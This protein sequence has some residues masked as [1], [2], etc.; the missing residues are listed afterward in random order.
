VHGPALSTA[1][2]SGLAKELGHD[3]TGW[4]TLG[5]SVDM[6]TVRTDDTVRLVEQLDESGGN[7]F[8]PVVEMDKTKHLAAVVHLRA[9]VLKVTA[10]DHVLVQL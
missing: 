9:H 8:L 3:G 5:Q 2:A 7:S 6:V 4:D 10:K 1:T